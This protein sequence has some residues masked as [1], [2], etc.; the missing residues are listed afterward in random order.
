MKCRLWHTDCSL[1]VLHVALDEIVLIWLSLYNCGIYIQ[2][3]FSLLLFSTF[4]YDDQAT[5]VCFEVNQGGGESAFASCVQQQ[6]RWVFSLKESRCR[7]SAGQRVIPGKSMLTAA[8]PLG[9]LVKTRVLSEFDSLY[10]LFC[11][12]G[13]LR[14]SLA[15]SSASCLSGLP[16]NCLSWETVPSTLAL[17]SCALA[18]SAA[19]LF[20]LSSSLE[21][22][23]LPSDLFSSASASSALW[24]LGCWGASSFPDGGGAP[25][26]TDFL[27]I[28]AKSCGYSD[29]E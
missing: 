11:S 13:E 12:S 26:S 15:F 2:G 24:E 3:Y 16:S 18:L 9:S 28:P 8:R 25:A 27:C 21:M 4:L 23:D 5:A 22:T 1:Q 20:S 19:M 10:G 17:C 29:L 7:P 14:G 6:T